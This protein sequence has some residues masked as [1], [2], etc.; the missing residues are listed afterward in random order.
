MASSNLLDRFMTPL[1]AGNRRTCR[2]LVTEELARTHSAT[3]VYAHLLWPAMERVEKLFRSDRINAASE[4]MATRINRSIAEQLQ[5][6]LIMSPP[7]GRR[8]IVLCADGEPEELGAQMTAGLFEAKGWEV[9]LLGSGVPNDEV[10]SLLGQLRPELLLVFGTTPSGVPGV[11][12]LVDLIRE[13]DVNPTMNIMVSGGVFNRADGLWKEVNA[14][15]F[16]K[17]AQEAI[18]LAEAAEPRIPVPKPPGTPKK[19]RR[20]RRPP[21]LAAVEG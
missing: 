8:I 6:H 10:L 19:R 13:I 12:K 9:F 14:E 3:E 15:L 2:D 5:S 16:A 17:T 21:L 20:R 1:L 4:H 11:R 18:P 7:H